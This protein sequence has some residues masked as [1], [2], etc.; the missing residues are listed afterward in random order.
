MNSQSQNLIEKLPQLEISNIPYFKKQKNYSTKKGPITRFLNKTNL[1]RK[2]NVNKSKIN[3]VNQYNYQYKYENKFKNEK[4]EM[5]SFFEL[6]SNHDDNEKD[7][8]FSSCEENS[9]NDEII[10]YQID[11]NINEEKKI[12]DLYDELD[13]I[14]NELIKKLNK[15]S[16]LLKN[17]NL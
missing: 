14:E 3:K 1:K 15:K 5:V 2:T 16:P 12:N 6:D 4:L 11:D 13:K 17:I 7:K 9:F 10:I 8:S